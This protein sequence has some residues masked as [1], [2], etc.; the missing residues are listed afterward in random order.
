MSLLLLQWS[1]SHVHLAQAHDHGDSHHHHSI[2]A[3]SHDINRHFDAT[4]DIA[5]SYSHHSAIELGYELNL[6]N[7]DKLKKQALAFVPHKFIDFVADLPGY[8]FISIINPIQVKP[9]RYSISLRA[10]PTLA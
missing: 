1:G 5:A 9:Y 4:A 3:H 10:P 2:E 7:S 6:Q 8:T